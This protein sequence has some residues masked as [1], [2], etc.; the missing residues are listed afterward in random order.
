VN[1]SLKPTI[2]RALFRLRICPGAAKSI[3]ET[4]GCTTNTY[5]IR[6]TQQISDLCSEG[7]VLLNEL[8]ERIKHY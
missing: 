6:K 1:G 2:T 3:F 5:L 7:T 4:Q 8:F